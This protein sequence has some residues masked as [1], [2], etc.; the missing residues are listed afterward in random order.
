MI[1]LD[2][3]TVR[4]EGGTGDRCAAL[5]EAVQHGLDNIN[6]FAGRAA[7][8]LAITVNESEPRVDAQ[9]ALQQELL[10]LETTL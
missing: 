1:K 8:R 2:K 3:E 5:R 6:E 9:S 10:S 4:L 7:E